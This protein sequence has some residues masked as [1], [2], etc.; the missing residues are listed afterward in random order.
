MPSFIIIKWCHLDIDCII[1]HSLILLWSDSQLQSSVGKDKTILDHCPWHLSSMEDWILSYISWFQ[2]SWCLGISHHDFPG[3]KDWWVMHLSKWVLGV[4]CALQVDPRNSDRETVYLSE[5]S[6]C[7]E[8][9]WSESPPKRSIFLPFIMSE[10]CQTDIRKKC[11]CQSPL[12]GQMYPYH[13]PVGSL[14][15]TPPAFN[16]TGAL[17]ANYG[18]KVVMPDKE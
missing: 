17:L 8:L 18:W 4:G 2:W 1:L 16:L 3:S 12:Y 6:P 9:S 5:S 13:N 15:G 7:H 14:G 11:S 10:W